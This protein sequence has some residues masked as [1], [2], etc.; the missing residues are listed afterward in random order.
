MRSIP[1]FV[2][3]ERPDDESIY[4]VGDFITNVLFGVSAVFVS[5][6]GTSYRCFLKVNH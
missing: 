5:N 1:L 4:S 3:F 6:V 2:V